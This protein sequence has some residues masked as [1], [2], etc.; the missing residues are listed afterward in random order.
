MWFTDGRGWGDLPE[1]TALFW[2]VP[3]QE[4]DT[5]QLSSPPP[6]YTNNVG[7]VGNPGGAAKGS[8][9]I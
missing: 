8:Y 9:G 3:Y 5:R 6:A 2:P 4:I 1:G 7:G